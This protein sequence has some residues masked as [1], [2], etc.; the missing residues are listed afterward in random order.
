MNIKTVL[1]VLAVAAF[2]VLAG[3]LR[4]TEVRSLLTSNAAAD[5]QMKS[6]VKSTNRH[7]AHRRHSRRRGWSHHLHPGW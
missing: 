3:P 6:E 2:I 1:G 4:S 7:P 5:K